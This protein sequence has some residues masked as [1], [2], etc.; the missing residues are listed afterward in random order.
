[1]AIKNIETV[2]LRHMETTMCKL[3]HSMTAR[4]SNPASSQ[5]QRLE[6]LSS[7]IFGAVS[8]VRSILALGASCGLTGRAAGQVLADKHLWGQEGFASTAR[9]VDSVCSSVLNALCKKGGFDFR[10]QTGA[11]NRNRDGL[12]AATGRI[13][14]FIAE[15]VSEQ[16]KKTVQAVFFLARESYE[17]AGHELVFA[18]GAWNPRNWWCWWSYGNNSHGV[19]SRDDESKGVCLVVRSSV[20]KQSDLCCWWC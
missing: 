16:F 10:G 5:R 13:E 11:Q 1:M 12:L 20:R 3:Y 15:G 2:N 7:L 19:W 14:L 4:A 17:I 9:A 18:D 8:F 6:L